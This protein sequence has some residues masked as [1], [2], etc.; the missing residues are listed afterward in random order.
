MVVPKQFEFIR[1]PCQRAETTTEINH[2]P[3]SR[4]FGPGSPGP[5]RKRCGRCVR[6]RESDPIRSP[7]GPGSVPPAARARFRPVAA[8]GRGASSSCVLLAA[9]CLLSCSFL[10]ANDVFL[11]ALSLLGF[12]VALLACLPIVAYGLLLVGCFLLL[13]CCCCDENAKQDHLFAPDTASMYGNHHVTYVDPEV[14]QKIQWPYFSAGEGWIERER[15]SVW[16]DRRGIS[17]S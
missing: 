16:R 11:G 5:G 8:A 13:C 7:R 3:S 10:Q 2:Q 6:L 9:C 15:Q 12:T 1:N 4:T 14:R 17:A